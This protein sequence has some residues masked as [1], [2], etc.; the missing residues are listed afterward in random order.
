VPGLVRLDRGETSRAPPVRM[1]SQFF[2]GGAGKIT[3]AC[4]RFT[5]VGCEPCKVH[6]AVYGRDGCQYRA[7]ASVH[8]LRFGLSIT[9][10]LQGVGLRLRGQTLI[11]AAEQI[12]MTK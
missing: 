9:T 2:P 3:V 10:P 8:D 7:Y 12:A 4:R 6:T 11:S 5:C 1:P